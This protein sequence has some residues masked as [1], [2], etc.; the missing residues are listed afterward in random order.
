MGVRLHFWD[1]G[2]LSNVLEYSTYNTFS[3]CH[4]QTFSAFTWKQSNAQ[5]NIPSVKTVRSASDI[6]C[7]STPIS[8]R[9]VHWAKVEKH[10]II[11]LKQKWLLAPHITM[12]WFHVSLRKIWFTWPPK[13]LLTSFPTFKNCNWLL[14]SLMSY[15]LLFRQ[16]PYSVISMKYQE[17][18]TTMTTRV[19][20]CCKQLLM[21]YSTF[22]S[23]PETCLQRVLRRYSLFK[24]TFSCFCCT[25]TW[26]RPRFVH[27]PNCSNVSATEENDSVKFWT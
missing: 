22:D 6:N 18:Q 12:D 9:S 27:F 16:F 2:L 23:C 10:N 3:L 4:A 25:K 5:Q 17:L 24:Y 1:Y 21:V 11:D 14:P 20:S 13:G 15:L 7:P 26:Q 8:S 19:H